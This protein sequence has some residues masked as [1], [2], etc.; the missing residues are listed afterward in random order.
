MSCPKGVTTVPDAARRARRALG[1][2]ARGDGG[3]GTHG[4]YAHRKGGK[5]DDRITGN[6]VWYGVEHFEGR[7][8]KEDNMPNWQR[9]TPFRGLQ[10][11]KGF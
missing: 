10:P 5:N 1:G 11:D 2:G 7:P 8:T 9:H 4:D 3:R 6:L